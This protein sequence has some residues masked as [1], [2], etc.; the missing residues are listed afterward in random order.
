VKLEKTAVAGNN[1][2]PGPLLSTVFE[3]KNESP[4]KVD[5]MVG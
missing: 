5:K 1:S 4:I 3:S 2:I